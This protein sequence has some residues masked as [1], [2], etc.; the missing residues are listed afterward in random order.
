VRVSL[1]EAFPRIM[2]DVQGSGDDSPASVV[3]KTSRDGI[4][5]GSAKSRQVGAVGAY[6]TRLVWRELGQF[7][8][9]TIE[10]SQSASVDIPLLAEID[11]EVV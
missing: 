6:D 10:L 2:G 4:E 5:F 9:A 8:R 11:V 7:R 3:L 1:I